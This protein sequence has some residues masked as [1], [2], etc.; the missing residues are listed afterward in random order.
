MPVSADAAARLEPFT[1]AIVPGASGAPATGFRLFN[2]PFGFKT[3]T[4]F[5]VTTP[6]MFRTALARF[7]A[8]A[9]AVTVIDVETLL[10]DQV[11]EYSPASGSVSFIVKAG[12][13]LENVVTTW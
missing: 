2:T 9:R 7:G 13:P 4:L 5:A 10:G 12:S 8:A 11:A 3:G 6:V 1:V